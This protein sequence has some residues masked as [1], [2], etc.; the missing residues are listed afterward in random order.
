MLWKNA[1][2]KI[3]LWHKPLH[4]SIISGRFQRSKPRKRKTLHSI[5]SYELYGELL[6][7]S[8][9]DGIHH[10]TIKERS[11]RHD[12]TIRTHR[13]RRL[14]QIFLFHSPGVFFRI[15]DVEH[16]SVEPTILMIPPKIPHGFLFSK[17]VSG[18]VVSIRLDEMSDNL[19]THFMQLSA[20]TDMIFPRSETGNF[21]AV[22][23]LMAQ[24]GQTFHSISRNRTDVLA[25]QVNLAALYLMGDLRQKNALGNA[26][27]ANPRG[28]QEGLVESFC[29]LLED[30][31]QEQWTVGDYAGRLEV[32]APHL[33]RL[34]RTVLG[35]PP[36]S[37][38]RQRRLLEAKR[39]LEYTGL[40][41]AEVAHRCGFRDAAFFSRT[42]KSSMNTT[43]QSFRRDLAPR[44]FNL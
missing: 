38:V 34:C 23:V 11:S 17:D 21:E 37:L 13:H 33:T 29:G 20:E 4:Y 31:F 36:N 19:K 9:S 18:H 15:G 35:S 40:S 2:Q 14:G 25:A 7:S 10:E 1:Y 41:I 30:H 39:L 8:L 22:S 5:P 32:S 26:N 12:W 16:T 44:S 42:F 24:L 27:V 6:A 43:P 28:R 3:D